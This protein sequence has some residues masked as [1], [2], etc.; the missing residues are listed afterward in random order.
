MSVIDI[1]FAKNNQDISASNTKTE[2]SKVASTTGKAV[3]SWNYL[4]YLES[5][6]YL[7]LRWLSNQNSMILKSEPSGANFPA[8]PS[9]IATITQVV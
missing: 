2:I 7:E 8:I 1:W 9:I 3:A 5:G 4:E 6:S